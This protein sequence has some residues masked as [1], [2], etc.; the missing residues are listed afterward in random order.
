MLTIEYLDKGYNYLKNL[1]K[2]KLKIEYFM[3]EFKKILK[4][5]KYFMNIRNNNKEWLI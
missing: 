3:N 4:D 1:N 5:I 2:D